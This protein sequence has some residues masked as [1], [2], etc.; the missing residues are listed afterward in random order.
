MGTMYMVK[1][2]DP[3]ADFPDDW[4][5]HVDRELRLVNDQ[6]S[7]YL[8]SSEI[9][10]FN[11]SDSTDW[12]DVSDE[13]ALVVETSIE[14]H[15]LSDGAFDITVA[16]LVNAWNFGPG[17]RTGAPPEP[18]R[19]AQL[20]E[21][22]GTEHLSVRRR[23][24]AIRKARPELT[25]DLSA[26]A[27]GH[28]VDRIVELLASLG[29]TN[30]FVEIGGDLRVSGDKGGELWKVGIEQPDQL[31]NVIAA[32]HPLRDMA[33]A[34]SGDYR[35]FFEVDGQHYSHTIDPRT[36]RP[37]QTGV[38]SVSV[39]APDCMTADAWAT[40]MG[41]MGA[42]AGHRVAEE[43]GLPT[44]IMFRDASGR[45]SATGTGE[46]AQHAE[47]VSS[48]A[49]QPETADAG[50]GF[51]EWMLIAIISVGAFAV[52]LAGMAIGVLFGRRSISGSC[53]GLAN[54]RDAEGNVSCSLCDNPENA[55]RELK[56]RMESKS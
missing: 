17:E 5:T 22:V 40:A 42:E 13:T 34:T 24:P 26:I 21:Q 50:D 16:P 10:R 7:T 32:A 27:K 38:A 11:R 39:I 29:A 48:A 43:L 47:A 33:I 30:T 4:Q 14:V 54:R 3:P 23:P 2:F 6:M 49:P 1:I 18:E 20:L 53:G 51:R 56:Q 19:I 12:F 35:N 36:G 28:G 25:I 52:V 9:S 44:L 41:V 46:L 8:E 31:G 45:I 37:I 55:C 15:R